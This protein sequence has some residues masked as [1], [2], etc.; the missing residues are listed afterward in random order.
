MSKKIYAIIPARGGSK[1]IPNKNLKHFNKK[2]LLFYAAKAAKE[3]KCF[4]KV[5]LSTDSKDIAEYGKEIG[6]E[7]PF[8]RDKALSTDKSKTIDLVY[9]LIQKCNLKGSICLIQA[10]S[11]LVNKKDF[12]NACEMHI[13]TNKTILSVSEYLFNPSILCTLNDDQTLKFLQ[14]NTGI[15]RQE[16]TKT[17]K[18]N[19][20]FFLNE[21]SHIIR[22]KTLAPNE[23]L[24]YIMP[25]YCS[26]DIDDH[27]DWELAQFIQSNLKIFK[28]K[29]YLN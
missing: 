5:I 7:V 1:G 13:R 6:L 28:N 21:I 15:P 11:P 24:P 18:L 14:K 23:S 8:L 29:T 25:K 27:V 12:M 17:Y 9:D 19:G 26:V 3:S 20:C 16:I 2:P 4:E 10:T 22:E